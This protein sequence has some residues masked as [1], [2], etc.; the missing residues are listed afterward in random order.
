MCFSA[1]A[2]FVGSGVLGTVGVTTLSKVKHR[3][4]LMFA[5]LPALFAVHQGI[6]GLF[7]WGW[8][9]ICH[10]RLCITWARLRALCPGSASAG[11]ATERDA[12]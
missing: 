6:E 10:R 9:G 3:R 8:M 1:T 11:N 4:E 2:N 7:G 12:V 5:S